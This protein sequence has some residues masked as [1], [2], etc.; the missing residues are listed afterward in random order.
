MANA[1]MN[2][3]QNR[4]GKTDA[5]DHA[6]QSMMDV[7]MLDL[8]GRVDQAFAPRKAVCQIF[9]ILRC[10]HEHGIAN[11]VQLDGNGHFLG[12]RP[13]LDRLQAVGLYQGEGKFLPLLSFYVDGVICH[14]LT[15]QYLIQSAM[16]K[17]CVS[18]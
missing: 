8:I 17:G 2:P 16:T 6:V 3:R 15:M 18:C 11:A 5:Q 9:Q 12:Y 1:I 13:L 7:D 4:A 10:R 14:G